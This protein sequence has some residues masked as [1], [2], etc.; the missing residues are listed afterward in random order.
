MNENTEYAD[1]YKIYSDGTTEYIDTRKIEWRSK[2]GRVI[3]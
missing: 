2:L 1:L 3:S